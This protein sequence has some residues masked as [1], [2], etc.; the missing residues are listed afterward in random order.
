[1]ERIVSDT[2]SV[3]GWWTY[4]CV[5]HWLAGTKPIC[6]RYECELNRL[7]CR[8]CMRWCNSWKEC[9]QVADAW[10][11]V[12]AGCDFKC[13]FLKKHCQYGWWVGWFRCTSSSKLGRQRKLD[14]FYL[15]F[16]L[17]IQ[18][19]FG[20]LTPGISFYR[21]CFN[22]VHLLLRELQLLL[23][24]AWCIHPRMHRTSHSA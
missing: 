21:F 4:P 8:I 10:K 9:G 7:G 17:R 1:M 6:D 19:V 11:D 23:G 15:F 16:F 12:G 14:K 20:A 2:K 18:F 24:L 5:K 3:C 22:R 13:E